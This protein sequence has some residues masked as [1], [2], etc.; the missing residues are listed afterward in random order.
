MLG[1]PGDSTKGFLATVE[2]AIELKPD[3]VR[4]YPALVIKDTPLEKLYTTGKYRT[5]SLDDAVQ[6]CKQA[7]TRFEQ[8]D[9]PV[10]RVGLQP[11]GELERPGTILAGPYHPAFRQLVE[12][13]LFLDRMR[14]TLKERSDHNDMVAFLVNPKDVSSA[15]GQKKTNITRLVNEFNL[16]ELRIQADEAVQRGTVRLA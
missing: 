2:K 6:S 15:T 13:S 5:L 16:R 8:A 7:L 11:T 9:I 3:F 14:K 10:I 12:A 1:L 4:I